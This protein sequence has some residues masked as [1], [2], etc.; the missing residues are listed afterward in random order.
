MKRKTEYTDLAPIDDI[1]NSDEYLN[2]LDWA[3]K[4][5]RVKNI[6]LAGPYGA[7]KSSVIET[8]L[9]E[10]KKI[11]RKSLRISMA[12]FSENGTDESGNLKKIQ[13][14]RNEIESGIL[15]Q[16]FYKVSYKI[17]PQSR[18]RKLHKIGWKCI[19]G[20]LIVLSSVLSLLEYI[21]FPDTF[22]GT[23]AKIK[24][25]G[26]NLGLKDCISVGLFCLFFLVMLAILAKG[27]R[28]ALSKFKVN[29]V[30][31]PTDTILKNDEE[32]QENIFNKNM[33]EIV[34]FF[35][36]TKYRIVFFEDLDRLEDSSIFI[37][38][39]ELN[40]LL[41][42]YD[43][44]KEPIIFVYA[45]K[46]DIFTD[47]DRT[48]FFDFIIP[49]IP[50]I[51]STNS[52]EILLEKLKESKKLGRTHEISQEYILDVS[53]YIS[54]MRIL[55]NVYNEFV[56]YKKTLRTEQDLKLSDESMMSLII[57]KNLY[58]RDFADIQM[59]KGIIKQAFID[60]NEFVMQQCG[61]WQEKIDNE[62]EILSQYDREILQSIK[63]IKYAMLGDLMGWTNMVQSIESGYSSYSLSS[64]M[65]DDFDLSKLAGWTRCT[66]VIY[67][68]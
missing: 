64:I 66:T 3:L 15:K 18:Y 5:K 28:S 60:K 35:E 41:N 24:T 13:I 59:E 65:R 27:Y 16:L 55:Q 50:I 2:A 46:D 40:T 38:L 39:R 31:L 29:E 48:K 23:I 21:F 44:I 61:V 58:P 56:L 43:V 7:G 63:E 12:T 30:K 17:I 19:W 53:P 8:Y 36:E 1:T 10:H 54:D 49:V 6:A 45:V 68:C 22:Y 4:N 57:F 26:S 25:A 47:T 33:D 11:K 62:S 34:Y 20:Y 52:G 32:A 42:N 37:Q 67:C 14:E 51:N 9:K